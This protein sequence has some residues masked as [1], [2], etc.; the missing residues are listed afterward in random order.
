MRQAKAQSN[1]KQEGQQVRR[2]TQELESQGKA[3]ME[4]ERVKA[5]A[6][7]YKRSRDGREIGKK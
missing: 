6:F 4:R 1:H 5:E 2:L 7:V 3:K